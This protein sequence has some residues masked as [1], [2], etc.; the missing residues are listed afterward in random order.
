MEMDLGDGSPPPQP[1]TALSVCA[2]WANVSASK[3]PTGGESEPRVLAQRLDGWV[4]LGQSLAD[5][6][7]SRRRICHDSEN[8]DTAP[9][10]AQLLA[11]GR[12]LDSERVRHVEELFASN[13]D[14]FFGGL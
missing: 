11:A 2:C 7:S 4:I 10:L 8:I 12:S 6:G 1:T 13:M 3:P 9:D 5:L 14:K